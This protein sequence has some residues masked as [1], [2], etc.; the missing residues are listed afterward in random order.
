ML[1]ILFNLMACL[2]VAD[3]I[4]GIVHWAEDTWGAPGRS[5]LLD[6]WIVLPNIDHHR[7][8]GTMRQA[9]YW[10]TNLVTVVLASLAACALVLMHVHAWQAYLIVALTSQSNQIHAWAHTQSAPSWVR[11]LQRFGILQSVRHHGEHHKRPYAFRFCAMTNFL[12]PVL[13]ATGF[14]RGLEWMIGQCGISVKR[15]SPERGG[16]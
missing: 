16:Y 5:K 14:W 9:K 15:T 1:Y 3:L 7:R 4:S 10:E 2:L 13:D 8:P 6:K 12:N 11:W